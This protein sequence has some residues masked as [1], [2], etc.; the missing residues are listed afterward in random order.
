M[1]DQFTIRVTAEESTAI[2]RAAKGSGMSVTSYLSEIIREAVREI[3]DDQSLKR[4]I[5]EGAALEA[6]S[7]RIERE[8]KG[9]E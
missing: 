7:Q 1:H 9:T 3:L 8:K 6:E 2:R 5:A 4:A